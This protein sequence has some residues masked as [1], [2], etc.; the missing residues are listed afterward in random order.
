[1]IKEMKG[2]EM[3]ENIMS[4]PTITLPMNLFNTVLNYL[5]GRPFVEVAQLITEM[6]KHAVL[7][8]V[9]PEKKP[10]VPEADKKSKK[11]PNPE[12]IQVS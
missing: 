6:Q 2:K 9:A 1:M 8:N 5:G 10:N 12:P 11:K 7:N 3:K 4:E